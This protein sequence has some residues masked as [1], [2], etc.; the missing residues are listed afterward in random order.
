MGL[1]KSTKCLQTRCSK[2]PSLCLLAHNRE[3]ELV[4]WIVGGRCTVPQG[5]I[6]IP[7]VRTG[8]HNLTRLLRKTC[9]CE[10]ATYI[11]LLGST[12]QVRIS[13]TPWQL[14]EERFKGLSF[15]QLQSVQRRV[16]SFNVFKAFQW[17]PYVGAAADTREDCHLATC[18]W[19]KVGLFYTSK[20]GKCL[21]EHQDLSRQYVPSL[22]KANIAGIYLY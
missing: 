11:L 10:N 13:D 3:Q 9:F 20:Q 22:E 2:L 12:W 17:G 8:L 15:C 4:H 16:L 21:G 7:S 14:P 5:S 6:Q 1:G 18:I 19:G